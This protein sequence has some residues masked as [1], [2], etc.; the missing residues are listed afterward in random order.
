MKQP[1]YIDRLGH[2]LV[3]DQIIRVDDQFARAID[4]A[5]TPGLREM[6]YPLSAITD[7]SGERLCRSLIPIPDELDQQLELKKRVSFPTEAQHGAFR[8][9][10]P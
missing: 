8:P 10:F 1:D 9:V 5:G 3:D 2:D 7:P 4:P 6:A